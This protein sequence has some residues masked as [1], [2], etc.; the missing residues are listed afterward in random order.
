MHVTI[1]SGA[2]TDQPVEIT[3]ARTVIVRDNFG[4]PIY[5]AIQQDDHNVLGIDASDPKFEKLVNELPLNRRTLVVE[6]QG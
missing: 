2:I 1:A 3:D 6:R 5:L 4:N